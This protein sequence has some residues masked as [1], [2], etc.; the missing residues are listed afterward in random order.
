[1]ILISSK[2]ETITFDSFCHLCKSIDNTVN[3]T[4][5]KRQFIANLP[6]KKFLKSEQFWRS[7][8]PLKK[9]LFFGHPIAI[10]ALLMFLFCI[11]ATWWQN[12]QGWSIL[13]LLLTNWHSNWDILSWNQ[14]Q[15][16]EFFILQKKNSDKVL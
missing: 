7:S 14:C 13:V 2:S 11:S 3:D 16:V 1:M 10:C 12:I 4:Q 5:I 9:Q 6:M 15:R 8:A